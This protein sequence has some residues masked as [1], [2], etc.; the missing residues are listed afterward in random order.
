MKKLLT[1]VMCLVLAIGVMGFTACG[2]STFKGDYKEVDKEK[3]AAFAA[4]I[5]SE[6]MALNLQSGIE[7]EFSMEYGSGSNSYLMEINVKSAYTA[8]QQVEVEGSW[9]TKM[10]GE[11]E[12]GDIY[13][14][15]G[16]AYMNMD[17]NKIKQA[18]N[19]EMLFGYV[20]SNSASSEFT[21]I[22]ELI[23]YLDVEPT[24]GSV[25]V[26]LDESETV[27][28]LKVEFNDFVFEGIKMDGE[29]YFVYNADG[30]LTAYK[31]DVKMTESGMEGSFYMMIKAYDGK[32][33]LPSDLDSYQEGQL[34]LGD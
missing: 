33:S 18:V 31:A 16:Y 21:D 12:K 13:Y 17:G 34:P 29:C 20:M 26:Y 6:G 19:Y 10:G 7:L 27:N 8:Q 22:Q 5:D 25:K 15:D 9:K 24:S 11:T 30:V 23:D 1:L 3:A 28:K 14:S 2:D 32:I 4:T